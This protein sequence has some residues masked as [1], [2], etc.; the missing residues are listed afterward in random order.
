[1]SSAFRHCGLTFPNLGWCRSTSQ[2]SGNQH[3]PVDFEEL[4]IVQAKFQRVLAASAVAEKSIRGLDEIQWSR[5]RFRNELVRDFEALI[6]ISKTVSSDLGILESDIEEA[7][8]SIGA[9]S[10]WTARALQTGAA[11]ADHYVQQLHKIIQGPLARAKACNS[12]FLRSYERIELTFK[13]QCAH[14]GLQNTADRLNL[15]LLVDNNHTKDI[16]LLQ[17]AIAQLSKTMTQLQEVDT[18]LEPSKKFESL[19]G[20]VILQIEGNRSLDSSVEVRYVW[21]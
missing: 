6:E 16:R 1:M 8:K 9:M 13:I 3:S 4:A 20:K 5:L 12:L 21:V 2:H 19:S 15:I 7:N 18:K 14:S 17:N 11:P 10:R